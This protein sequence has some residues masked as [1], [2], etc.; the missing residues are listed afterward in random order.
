MEAEIDAAWLLEIR[1]STTIVP[2]IVFIE[3]CQ[4][5]DRDYN[6]G[7]YIDCSKCK[8]NVHYECNTPQVS[9]YYIKK[10]DNFK[11]EKCK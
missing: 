4:I 3:K 11:C 9:K 2:I 8:D 1:L 10:P 7:K 6:D 5:C